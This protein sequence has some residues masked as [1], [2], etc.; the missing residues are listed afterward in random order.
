MAN[1]YYNHNT[2][3]PIQGSF[4]ASSNVRGEFD[5]IVAGFNLLPALG[6][7]TAGQTVIS[8]SGGTALV[9]SNALV[10]DISGNATFA[11][12]VTLTGILSLAAGSVNP[13]ELNFGSAGTGFYAPGTNQIALSASGTQALLM[14]SLGAFTINAPTGITAALAVSNF[15]GSSNITIRSPGAANFSYIDMGRTGNDFS[16]AVAGAAGNFL[17]PAAQGDAVLG[18]VTGNYVF[19]A[20]GAFAVNFVTNNLSRGNIGSAGNWTVATPT[21]GTALTVNAAPAGATGIAVTCAASNQC[22]AL[23][24][25]Q[26]GQT[27]WLLYQ[28]S[29]SSDF[30]IYGGRDTLII[31]NS[32]N[33]T[34]SAPSSGTA[35]TVNG[36][37]GATGMSV[38]GTGAAY[39][40]TFEQGT[41][42]DVQVRINAPTSFSPVL[43]LAINAT[44][45]AYIGVSGSAGAYMSGDSAGDLFIR[46]D[47]GIIGLSLTG[48]AAGFK[49]SGNSV[50]SV[51]ADAAGTYYEVGFR[52]IPVVTVNGAGSTA[53][54]VGWRGMGVQ[55]GGSSTG[56]T[57][58]A[59][60]FN[61]GD[62]FTGDNTLGSTVTVTQGA[63]VT[64]R[65]A[66]G[67]TTGNRTVAIHGLFTVYCEVGG[68]TPTFVISGN[69]S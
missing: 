15:A 20:F 3:Q 29:A 24:F 22:T 12:K 43:D 68:A 65:L 25:N 40:A 16:I 37:S 38:T 44:V 1:S 60:I 19:G 39:T 67:T 35:L 50:S 66:G 26:T 6:G 63:S 4:G 27:Q 53:A 51:N 57:L 54:V 58:N 21:S 2:G 59:S 17:G 31:N 64:L 52:S 5:A 14:S 8:N 46:C 62:V 69:V 42:A 9:L 10:F 18:A 33:V 30:R 47:S 28:P 55:I 36:V 41:T 56:I 32:G 45:K 61:A 48:A 7:A 23:A 11:N 13:V 34:V 49:L